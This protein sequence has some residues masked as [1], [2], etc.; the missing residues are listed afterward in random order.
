M[1]EPKVKIILKCSESKWDEN[2]FLIWNQEDI[3]Y[4][5]NLITNSFSATFLK[6]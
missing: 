3:L 5:L 2:N 1:Y 4:F 6:Y